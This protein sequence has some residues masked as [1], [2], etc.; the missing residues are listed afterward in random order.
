M[1]RYHEITGNQTPALDNEHVSELRS[2]AIH[3]QLASWLRKNTALEHIDPE[4]LSAWM[5]HVEGVNRAED[6]LCGT[7][8]ARFAGFFDW[9]WRSNDWTWGRMDAAAGIADLLEATAR[10]EN[11][12]QS[13]ASESDSTARDLQQCIFADLPTSLAMPPR[14]MGVI[15]GLPSSYR[16]GLVSRASSLVI[17]ALQPATVK[18]SVVKKSIVVAAVAALRVIPPLLGLLVDPI[19]LAIALGATLLASEVLPGDSGTD[20]S[21]WRVFGFLT[22][23]VGLGIGWRWWAARK[24]WHGMNERWERAKQVFP[25]ERQRVFTDWRR[26]FTEA[27]GRARP[28]LWVTLCFGVA[29]ACIGIALWL[30]ATVLA[31]HPMEA[32]LAVW[33]PLLGLAGWLFVVCTRVTPP[34]SGHEAGRVGRSAARRLA[35]CCAAGLLIVVVVLGIGIDISLPGTIASAVSV[36]SVLTAALVACSLWGWVPLRETYTYA[37]PAALLAGIVTGVVAHC[38]AQNNVLVILVPVATW[39]IWMAVFLGN[40]TPLSSKA[41]GLLPE[42]SSDDT[43]STAN[44]S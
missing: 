32:A 33:F 7:P 43:A 31:C 35:F 6:K 38:W 27:Q 21:N 8:L 20:E 42:E 22:T 9:R 34:R 23:L 26:A 36:A 19:R 24:K 3:S 4:Q 30:L 28:Y 17:R 16:V 39:W 40:V 18:P 25:A 2:A 1:I 13:T 5:S 10:D 11:E 14:G 37:A 15:T 41:M 12:E 29:Y 44:P